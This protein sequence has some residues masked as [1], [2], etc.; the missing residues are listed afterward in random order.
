MQHFSESAPLVLV[1]CGNMGQAMAMGWLRAGLSPDHLFVVDP[2]AS[3]DRLLGAK[4]ENFVQT[5]RDLPVGLK[6]RVI[7]LAVKPQMMDN[8]IG[9][10]GPFVDAN[11]MIISVAAG[12]TL[13]QL[14]GGIGGEGTY[15]RV[16]PNTPAAIGEGISGLAADPDISTENKCLAQELMHAVGDTV[17]VDDERLIDSVTSVSGS[18]PAYVFYMVE[19][20]AAAGVAQGL[21]EEVAMKLARQTVVGAAKLMDTDTDIPAAE[22]RRRVTSPGGT[23]AA[24]LNI[25]MQAEGGLGQLMEKAITA[26]RERGQEL[27]G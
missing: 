25:L 16:M 27:G 19:C 11:T 15:V 7:V 13:G 5:A 17:W 14:K 6:A 4:T 12:I 24:A 20:M 2:G 9:L 21:S 10:F 1:G 23:T 26:A 18:G 3:A 22:L 8:V